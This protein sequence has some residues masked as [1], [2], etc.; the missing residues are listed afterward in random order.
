MG[1]NHKNDTPKMAESAEYET[2]WPLKYELRSFP[3]GTSNIKYQKSSKKYIYSYKRKK[4]SCD[5]FN[6]KYENFNEK[7]T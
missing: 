5:S 3:P 7:K 6:M 4:A 2:P 1:L